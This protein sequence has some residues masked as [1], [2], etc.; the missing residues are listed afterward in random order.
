[1]IEVFFI[2]GRVVNHTTPNVRV[3]FNNSVEIYNFSVF[4]ADTS[5]IFRRRQFN[6]AFFI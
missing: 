6:L 2:G 3:V 1:M 4:P 5:V